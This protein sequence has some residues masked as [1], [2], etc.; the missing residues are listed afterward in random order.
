[1][2]CLPTLSY[3]AGATH[4]TLLRQERRAEGTPLGSFNSGFNSASPWIITTAT[5]GS[6]GV[7]GQAIIAKNNG[8]LKDGPKALLQGLNLRKA[9]GDT[10]DPTTYNQFRKWLLNATAT[11]MLSA[12]PAATELDVN[13]GIPPDDGNAMVYA[14]GAN[15]AGFISVNNLMSEADAAL[16]ANGLTLDG[17]PNRA[18]QQALKRTLLT[19]PTTT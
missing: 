15:A 9:N 12:Q 10:F 14:P 13:Y 1:V 2:G 7:S 11:N 6:V 17:S 5:S 3:Y 16:L 4:R 18:D 19:S 8:D